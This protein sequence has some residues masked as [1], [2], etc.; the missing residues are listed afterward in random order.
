MSVVHGFSPLLQ[1]V[2]PSMQPVSGMWFWIFTIFKM[3]A[4]FFIYLV[5]FAVS[6]FFVLV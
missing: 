3:V 1:V 6:E 4:I 2:D 5:C